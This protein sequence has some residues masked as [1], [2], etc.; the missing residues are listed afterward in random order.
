[1]KR[2]K[3]NLSGSCARVGFDLRRERTTSDLAA[4]EQSATYLLKQEFVV[5]WLRT[6]QEQTNPPKSVLTRTPNPG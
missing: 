6:S 5:D 2:K 1:M 3:A 4:E